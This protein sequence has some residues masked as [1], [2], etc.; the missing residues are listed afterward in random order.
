MTRKAQSSD[1]RQP[2]S[3]AAKRRTAPAKRA[4]SASP[5]INID[6]S[7]EA[8]KAAR[9]KMG[10]PDPIF[11]TTADG[12]QDAQLAALVTQQKLTHDY[13]L[14]IAKVLNDRNDITIDNFKTE[15]S[16]CKIANL[17]LRRD[18]FAVRGTMSLDSIT[19]YRI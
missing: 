13:L 1:T 9:P 15:I 4:A 12:G 11:V 19:N 10:L 3:A 2:A 6:V 5:A 18:L 14:G 16:G 17:Q 8:P 7:P